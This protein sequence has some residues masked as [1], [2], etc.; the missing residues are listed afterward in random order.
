MLSL[1]AMRLIGATL[2]CVAVPLGAQATPATPA[3]AAA[4]AADSA[5][6]SSLDGIVCALYASISGPKGMPRDFAR[7]RSLMAP[8]ARFVPTGRTAAGVARYRSWS[9]D[10]Y[11]AAAGPR[12]H[13]KR[14]L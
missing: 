8:E 4:V 2:A 7:L 11:I 12:T 14:F 13:G 9:L 5:D 10:E 6:V 3:P 1:S